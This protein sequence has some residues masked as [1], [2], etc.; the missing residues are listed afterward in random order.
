MELSAVAEVAAL[1]RVSDS[2]LYLPAEE[3]RIPAVRVG[4]EGGS[5]RFERVA[6]SP[7]G[8]LPHQPPLP[9]PA[10]PSVVAAAFAA[11]VTG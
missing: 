10:L 9:P 5:V 4:G 1:P 6:L 2:W 3:G 11:H 8:R 7:P